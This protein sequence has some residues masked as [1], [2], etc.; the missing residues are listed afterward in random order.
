M[1]RQKSVSLPPKVG[2][3]ASLLLVDSNKIDVQKDLEPRYIFKCLCLTDF[4]VT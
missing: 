2:K 4:K 1:T 3:L